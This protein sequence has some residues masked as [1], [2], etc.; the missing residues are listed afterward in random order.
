MDV[1]LEAAAE[2]SGNC[3]RFESSGLQRHCRR[4]YLEHTFVIPVFLDEDKMSDC[5]LLLDGI[6]TQYLLIIIFRIQARPLILLRATANSQLLRGLNESLA[7][8]SCRCKDE[9][10]VMVSQE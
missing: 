7:Q 4:S 3:I 5:L 1:A 10:Y 6:Q 9:A 8:V 2:F